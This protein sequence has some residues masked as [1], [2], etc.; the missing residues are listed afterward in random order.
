MRGVN[1]GGWFVLERE[2]LLAEF[3]LPNEKMLSC[4]CIPHSNFGPQLAWITPS[5]FEQF[6]GSVVGEYNLCRTL[7]K[8]ACQ[9]QL[10]HHWR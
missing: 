10:E 1:L 2:S 5:L 6:G 8:V 4:L 3:V 9:S 7:G